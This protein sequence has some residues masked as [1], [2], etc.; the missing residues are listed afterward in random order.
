MNSRRRVLV[1]AEAANPEWVSVS[2]VGWS[3]ANALRGV[4][5]VH[6]VTQVRNRAAIERAGFVEGQD[7]TSIDTEALMKPLWKLISI[8]RG[9]EGKGWTIVTAIQSLSYVLFERIV[10]KRFGKSIEAFQFDVI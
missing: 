2:L 4:A 3:I 5:D 6:L 1:I 9:G 7:F 10:W 8:I